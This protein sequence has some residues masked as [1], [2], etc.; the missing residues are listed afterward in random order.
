MHYNE[1]FKDEFTKTEI[2][3]TEKGNEMSEVLR[4]CANNVNKMRSGRGLFWILTEV[5]MQF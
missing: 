5:D 4:N 3:F 2:K 1:V